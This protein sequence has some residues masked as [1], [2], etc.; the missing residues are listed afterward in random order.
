MRIENKHPCKI[1]AIAFE[2]PVKVYFIRHGQTEGNVQG[3]V[4]GSTDTPLNDVGIGQAKALAGALK[5][6]P[7]DAI[8]AS[9]LQRAY[10]TAGYLAE[11]RDHISVEQDPLLQEIHG[12]I[13]ETMTWQEAIEAFP[14]EYAGYT[15]HLYKFR[16]PGGE[17]SYEV[18]DRALAFLEKTLPK[19]QGESIAVVAH[20]FLLATLIN[21]CHGRALEEAPYE[22]Y[23]NTS[24]SEIDFYGTR[25]FELIRLN[26]TRHVHEAKD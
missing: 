10:V 21:F 12:G 4:Q 6:I 16:A 14:E 9:N 8:Y 24:I 3:Y 15:T 18:F 17:S 13:L 20:G 25:E 19:H 2:K 11:G 23:G 1:A 26:D 7:L 5:D 22:I